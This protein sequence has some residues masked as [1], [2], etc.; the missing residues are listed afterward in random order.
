MACPVTHAKNLH[1]HP[2]QV[3]LGMKQ[4]QRTKEQKQ[5]DDVRAEQARQE[6]ATAQKEE[7][8]LLTNPP[9]LRPLPHI[10]VRPPADP[11]STAKHREQAQ[12]NFGDTM[13]I[14]EEPQEEDNL[15]DA[16]ADENGD[17]D[18]DED[19]DVEGDE[20]D[21]MEEE[22]VPVSK[23]QRI[24]KT[25]TRDAVQVAQG[26][27]ND[28]GIADN[29]DSQPEKDNQ[30]SIQAT[31]NDVIGIGET[32]DWAGKLAS[33]KLPSLVSSRSSAANSRH[34]RSVSST[35][36]GRRAPPP[37]LCS[38]TRYSSPT[39]DNLTTVAQKSVPMFACFTLNNPK[40][41]NP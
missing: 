2:G 15:D 39:T 13:G 33:A 36:K 6:E 31:K 7:Q 17:V 40:L 41:N 16:E 4:K 21:S 25:I 1:Q 32:K 12:V 20:D 10:V 30:A 19:G 26:G 18:G 11:S 29:A 24:Q 34:A 8:G 14:E 35:S 37:S 9:K 28:R 3:I 38:S 5:E 27:I 23:K 22:A